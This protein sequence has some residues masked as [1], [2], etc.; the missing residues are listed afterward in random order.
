MTIALD[1]GA[2]T[3]RSLRRQ[4]TR[5]VARRSRLAYAVLPGS[6]EHR[7]LLDAARIPFAVCG[8]QFVLIGG[9]AVDSA[10]LFRERVCTALCGG[11][12]PGDN[13]LARQVVAAVIDAVLPR[14]REPGEVCCLTLP[15]GDG[16]E[17][18]EAEFLTRI[19]RLAGYT[20]VTIPAGMALLLAELSRVSFTGVALSF[21]AATC[22][23][24]VAHRGREIASTGITRAGEWI[25]SQIAEQ[26]GCFIWDA[27]GRRH[28]DS[29]AVAMLK[30]RQTEPL[31]TSSS[32]CG[33]RLAALYRDVID[34][35][36]RRAAS[37]FADVPLLATLP[38]PLEFVVSGGPVRAAGFADLLNERLQATPLPLALAPARIADDPEYTIARGCLIGAE[39]EAGVEAPA[40]AHRAAA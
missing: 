12:L 8:G 31:T 24:T 2:Q 5:L 30:A 13:P 39:L 26:E 21:G 32:K 25:D 28:F 27:A 35:L 10:G 18:A 11:K 34:E 37:A 14:A 19:V 9:Q 15:G 1:I 38:R 22:E 40:Q 36:C 23:M 16:L 29:E 33:Q 6:P 20:P 4:G 7:R 3:V 17:G